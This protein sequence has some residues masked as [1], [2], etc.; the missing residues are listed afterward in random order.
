MAE[1]Y[2]SN[3]QLALER[4]ESLY[5]IL[6]APEVKHNTNLNQLVKNIQD[7]VKEI[8]SSA[9]EYDDGQA[10]SQF[11]NLATR[12]FSLLILLDD[13]KRTISKVK[14]EIKSLQRNLAADG[15]V[16]SWVQKT[17]KSLARDFGKKIKELLVE[18]LEKMRESALYRAELDFIEF[19]EVEKI[20][21]DGLLAKKTS[22]EELI[23]KYT[24][25]IRFDLKTVEK[26]AKE[27]EARKQFER[28]QDLVDASPNDANLKASLALASKEYSKVLENRSKD[29]DKAR[30]LLEA[31]QRI[32]NWD[33]VRAQ[34][35]LILFHLKDDEYAQSIKAEADAHQ[36][37]IAKAKKGEVE[38]LRLI[39][40]G[41][42][43]EAE[44]T[45]QN[46]LHPIPEPCF[47]LKVNELFIL[48]DFLSSFQVKWDDLLQY[49]DQ[50]EYTQVLSI[51]QVL[52]EGQENHLPLSIRE[53][54]EKKMVEWRGAENAFIEA[55]KLEQGE[56]AELRSEFKKSKQWN[57]LYAVRQKVLELGGRVRSFQ[58]VQEVEKLKQQIENALDSA[59]AEEVESIVL[60]TGKNFQSTARTLDVVIPLLGDGKLDVK[61]EGIDVVRRFFTEAGRKRHQVVIENLQK[62]LEGYSVTSNDWLEQA[63]RALDEGRLTQ[64]SRYAEKADKIGKDKDRKAQ[65]IIRDVQSQQDTLTQIRQIAAINVTDA[66]T[67]LADFIS[68]HDRH[69]D[70]KRLERELEFNAVDDVWSRALV[71]RELQKQKDL[72][73]SAILLAPN[74][75]LRKFWQDK[76]VELLNI[77]EDY[78]NAQHFRLEGKLSKAVSLLEKVKK[79]DKRAD[80]QID[81]INH[82][83]LQMDEASQSI[84]DEKYDLG[85]RFFEEIK[86]QISLPEV[87]EKELRKAYFEYHQKEAK[88]SLQLYD[89]DAVVRNL[90]IA[91]R[92]SPK[93]NIKV[94]KQ[95]LENYRSLLHEVKDWEKKVRS[96]LDQGAELEVKR[97]LDA[98]KGRYGDAFAIQ[99]GKQAEGFIEKI[100]PALRT[101]LIDSTDRVDRLIELKKKIDNLDNDTDD[102]ETQ[103]K[104]YN[105]YL[106]LS[107][108]VVPEYKKQA[109]KLDAILTERRKYKS[110]FEIIRT[111]LESDDIEQLGQAFKRIEELEKEIIN[112]GD[113]Y[114]TS[115]YAKLSREAHK[116]RTTFKEYKGLIDE[117]QRLISE[118]QYQ[119]AMAVLQ[120]AENVRNTPEVQGLKSEI[121]SSIERQLVIADQ[122]KLVENRMQEGDWR[123][124]NEILIQIAA[125]GPSDTSQK[126]QLANLRDRVS[127]EIEKSDAL[128]RHF[129][130]MRGL[131]SRFDY[132]E[133]DKQL[134]V[135]R[136]RFGNR[137]EFIE[138]EREIEQVRQNCIRLDDLLRRA[139][140]AYARNRLKESEALY[141]EAR[142]I[143]NADEIIK[144]KGWHTIRTGDSVKNNDAQSESFWDKI[145]KNLGS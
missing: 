66:K 118:A 43:S 89:L 39:A 136:E 33:E 27:N 91:L 64:A 106:E 135:A 6:L 7:T 44:R 68:K 120:R 122:F 101:E 117:A 23:K 46:F 87:H 65:T 92:Y 124:A 9:P 93:Q 99:L 86:K 76:K 57:A 42:I 130:I 1:E 131:L 12:F 110:E 18:V 85:I 59:L 128:K 109:D 37:S 25:S 84:K 24:T 11:A 123:G 47:D 30:E 105:Q 88:D 15:Y 90:E 80:A 41:K 32:G 126:A 4:V 140:E 113:S 94:I 36:A 22:V 145:K 16:A 79:F 139:N 52:L 17:N 14:S 129:E 83:S 103:L 63:Q 74:L 71:D 49:V 142:L 96:F 21:F 26:F 115:E 98:A 62:G 144:I 53:L 132:E 31:A 2:D 116:T 102:P 72:V 108:S 10:L 133:S 111:K 28:L 61:E 51:S 45:L 60:K 77:Q 97:N 5:E 19:L 40:E 127:E 134:G 70:A 141:T 73:N 67:K 50:N 58:I 78:N 20:V 121:A 75:E 3:L 34:A 35:N 55:G 81:E 54:L 138:I 119:P 104:I 112:A 29:I 143:P 125:I 107:I 56:L 69:T 100:Y 38:V 8:P 82:L 13:P 137:L 95:N 114:L 48:R